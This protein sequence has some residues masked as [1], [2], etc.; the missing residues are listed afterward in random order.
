MGAGNSKKA[1][2]VVG[3]GIGGGIGAAIGAALGGPLGA[4]IGAAVTAWLGHTIEAELD[5]QNQTGSKA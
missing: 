2:K 3:A 1:N 4:V 5:H